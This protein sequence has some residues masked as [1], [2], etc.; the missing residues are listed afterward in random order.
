MPT[1]KEKKTKKVTLTKVIFFIGGVLLVLAGIYSIAFFYWDPI[2]LLMGMVY[3]V[4][5]MFVLPPTQ[6]Y[7]NARYN[8]KFSNVLNLTILVIVFFVVPNLVPARNELKGLLEECS[9]VCDSNNWDKGNSDLKIERG[10][11]VQ[12]LRCSQSFDEKDKQKAREALTKVIEKCKCWK[13][14]E[15]TDFCEE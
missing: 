3:L 5:G 10:L 14:Y 7:I 9:L 4:A 11:I 6:G 1:H 15:R 13:K 2:Q 12:R 8:I